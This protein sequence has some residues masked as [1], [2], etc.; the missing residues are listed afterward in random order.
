MCAGM[1]AFAGKRAR[2]RENRPMRTDLESTRLFEHVFTQHSH[3]E[4]SA[5]ISS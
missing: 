4:T 2:S 3:S 5:L 1:R